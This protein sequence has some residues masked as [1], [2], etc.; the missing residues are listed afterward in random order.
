MVHTNIIGKGRETNFW[1][2]D[3]CLKNCFTVIVLLL[4]ISDVLLETLS[5]DNQYGPPR[6]QTWLD[7]PLPTVTK[8]DRGDGCSYGGLHLFS[9]DFKSSFAPKCYYSGTG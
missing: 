3:T 2:C 7:E 9:V 1:K 5:E 6:E 8:L 4:Y